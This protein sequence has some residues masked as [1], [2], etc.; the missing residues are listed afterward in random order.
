MTLTYKLNKMRLRSTWR[1]LRCFV[2]AP[3]FNR[4]V[5]NGY[6]KRSLREIPIETRVESVALFNF[7]P[8]II[9]LLSSSPMTE[10][11]D[12]LYESLPLEI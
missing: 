10:L 12:K 3:G 8:S 1:A 11:R 9:Y 4:E 2:G 7:C 5:V 6:R